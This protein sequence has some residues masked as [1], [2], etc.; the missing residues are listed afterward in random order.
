MTNSNEEKKYHLPISELID[1]L[2]IL[3]IKL[4]LNSDNT[5]EYLTELKLLKN[6]INIELNKKPTIISMEI[7][8]ILIA[9]GQ[10]NLHIW[11]IKNMMKVQV[12]QPAEYAA[13]MKLAHQLNGLR[14]QL[15]NELLA[16]EG[17]TNTA[18]VR[19]NIEVD[20]LTVDLGIY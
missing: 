11:Y 17:E 18:K 19:S 4:V 13:S 6:D 15:K 8:Q 7:I 12:N 10:M 3:Q 9:L 1:R 16:L 5:T 14:N 2:T 20:G